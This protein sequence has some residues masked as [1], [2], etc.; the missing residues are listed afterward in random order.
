MDAGT[1]TTANLTGLGTPGLATTYHWQVRASNDIG[2]TYANSGAE[3]T[4]QVGAL[5]GTFSLNAPA[6]GA[7][8]QLLAP[9]LSWGTSAGSTSYSYCYS[10]TSTD[11]SNS[12]V[13]GTWTVHA[14]PV[15]LPTLLEGTTYY[16]NA[17]ADNTYGT[18]YGSATPRSF[19][20]GSMP[21]AFNKS[22]PSNGA[23]DQLVQ[24][25]LTWS[26]STNAASYDYCVS[27]T[28]NTCATWVSAG[29]N[30]SVTLPSA[31]T[32][33]TTY[34]WQVRANSGAGTVYADGGTPTSVYYSFTTG[35]PPGAF[36]HSAPA[37]SATALATRGT[38]L[39]WTA[40]AGAT[41]YD[42]CY[43]TGPNCN[44]GPWINVGNTTSVVLDNLTSNKTY[45]WQVRATNGFGTSYAEGAI[46]TVWQFKTATA[47]VPGAPKKSTPANGA[48]GQATS[49]NLTWTA[50][51]G[52]TT[53]YQYCYTTTYN[54]CTNTTGPWQ[55]N[56][57]ATTVAISSLSQSTT[58]YWQVRA[59]NAIGTV[60]ADDVNYDWS[61]T[62]TGPTSPFGKATLTDGTT[63][64]ALMPTLTWGASTNAA[65]YDYCVSLT[66]NSCTTWTT[67]V[68]GTSVTLATALLPNTTYYWQVRA[69][70]GTTTYADGGSDTSGYW[71]FTTATFV[72]IAPANNAT[73]VCDTGSCAGPNPGTRAVNLTWSADPGA[74]A[75]FYCIDTTAAACGT[76]GS[77]TWVNVGTSTTFQV[78]LAKNLQYYWHVRATDGSGTT[79]TDGA[80]SSVYTFKTKG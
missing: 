35:T 45:H 37:N 75:Y 14:S 71:S 42:Y 77:G 8:N 63:N 20:T 1:A 4:F 66:N 41:S 44:S 73:N 79:Y 18:T 10:T 34:Y 29:T 26:A 21:T 28:N 6:N 58:Y 17:K 16:W 11:C 13:G 31:L 69:V 52:T 55:G 60:Y 67:G 62:T 40:S 49:L 15:T 3:F 5:P 74:T 59:Q 36:N 68:T 7:T 48:A 65:T 76:G 54:G 32:G 50:G 53:A 64:A 38:T 80:D 30:T 9:S 72:K 57:T 51:T 23:I 78:T 39:T 56:G 2:P 33:G 19:T 47:A 25:Q 70:G 43:V 27:L 46:A 12:G 61:F 24:P 22:T